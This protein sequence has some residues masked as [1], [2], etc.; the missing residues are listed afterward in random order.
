MLKAVETLVMAHNNKKVGNHAT[1]FSQNCEVQ[2]FTYHGN[3]I[4]T[5]DWRNK[6][7][8]LSNCGWNTSSTNRALNDYKRY[9]SD[10]RNFA[11]GVEFEI[12]DTRE[13]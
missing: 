11:P 8:R 12:T 2:Y 4:C 1:Y 3:I 5:V 7:V 13:K 9:F 10:G 6:T